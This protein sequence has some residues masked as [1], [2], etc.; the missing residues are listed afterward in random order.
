MVPPVDLSKVVSST[1]HAKAIHVMDGDEYNR[2]Y[3]SQKKVNMV[4]EVVVN[5][6]QKITKQRRKKLYVISDYKNPDGSVKM[7]KLHIK[8]VIEGP[9]LVPVPV[10]IPATAPLLTA[11]KTTSAPAN[12]STILPADHYTLVY[13]APVPITTTTNVAP[14]LIPIGGPARIIQ[15]F[16][17]PSYPPKLFQPSGT[18]HNIL[19]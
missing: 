19:S 13:P 11:T 1:V 8:S 18:T 4:E 17:I 14:A 9:V 7:A 6:E 10:N 2:L 12:P 16:H 5:V 3:G 15:L